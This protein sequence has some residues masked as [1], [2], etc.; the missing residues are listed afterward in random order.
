MEDYN[1]VNYSSIYYSEWNDFLCRTK[2]ATFLF[3]RDFMEY[4]SDRFE[5]FSLM[6]YKKEKLVALFPANVSG[7][8]IY[9]HQ[10]LSYGGLVL[11]NDIKLND[12]LKVF[13]ALLEYL[14]NKKFKNLEVKLL[15]SIYST[16]PNNE[17]NYITFLLDG[18]LIKRDTLSVINQNEAL[19]IS[20]NRIEGCKRGL[21]NNLKIIEETNF[22]AFWNT[23]LI[24]NLKS[25]YNT[26]PVHSLEEIKHLKNKFPENIRQFN[27]YHNNKI[28]GGTTIFVSKNVAHCQY[29]SGNSDSNKLGSLDLLFEH[30]IKTVFADK[31]YFDFGA[32]NESNGMQINSG[33]QFWKEGFG[34]RTITQDFYSILIANYKNLNTVLI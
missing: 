20:K 30:L 25:K 10:G 2:N 1:V 31:P 27:V 17:I 23:I 33:L 14:H 18:T 29:I 24:P 7:S 6:I 16:L 26:N 22:E 5:D 11:K 32:S 34:A 9:S 28:V 19:S 21:K 3:D 8:T 12:V 15:P 13:E 4:H